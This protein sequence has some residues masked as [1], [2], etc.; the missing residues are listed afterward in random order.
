MDDLI[1]D[2]RYG[3]RTLSRSK[4]YAGA[5][6]LTLALGIGANAAIFSVFNALMFRPLPVRDAHELVVVASVDQH[7]PDGFPHGLSYLDSLDYAAFDEVLQ[8][9]AT[10]TPFIVSLSVDDVAER[11]FVELVS[12]NYF[13]MLGVKPHLGRLIGRDEGPSGGAGGGHAVIVLTESYWQRRFAA[14]PD[15]VGRAVRINGNPYTVIGVVGE[16]FP[17]TEFIMEMDAYVPLLQVAELSQSNGTMLENREGHSLRAMGRLQPGVDVDTARTALQVRAAQLAEAYPDTNKGVSLYVVP[18]TKARPEPG[19]SDFMPYIAMVFMGLVG[20]ILAIACANV[21]NMMLARATTRQREIA[22]RAALGASRFR[23]LRQ[24]LTESVALSAASA[25]V[26][27]ALAYWA[28]TALGSVSFSGDFPVRIDVSL[29]LRVF[30][31]ALALSLLTGVL[32]GLFPG[33]RASRANLH[34]NL[35]EGGRSSAVDPAQHWM[36]SALVVSQVAISLVVLI[37]AGLFLRSVRNVQNI[38]LGFRSDNLLLMSMD[39]TLGGYDEEFARPMFEEL[40][41]ST[42]QMPGVETAAHATFVPFGLISTTRP[43]FVPERELKE[44]EPES[45]GVMTDWVGLDFF[46]TIG[47]PIRQGRPFAREDSAGVAPVAVVNQAFVDEFWPGRTAL[48]R[49]I[50]LNGA[51]GPFVEV[52]GVAGNSYQRLVGEEFRP[53]LYLPW[54]QT[55]QG[56][57]VLH[58]Y[59]QGD[60]TALAAAIRDRARALAPGM[61]VY[62]VLTMADHLSG[63]NAFMAQRLAALVA[64]MFGAV[65]LILATIGI[66]GVVSYSVSQRTREIGVRMALGAAAGDVQRLIVLQASKVTL[67]GVVLGLLASV[68][69]T[70]LMGQLLLDVSPTDPVTFLAVTSALTTIAFA[71]SYIPA[72]RATRVDPIIAMRDE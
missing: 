22:V 3:I 31:F 21:A 47:I 36:R 14:D 54:S 25:A 17:G 70:R 26:A 15:V 16:S 20:L 30:G 72:R 51:A 5:A 63:G 65:G 49:Q 64:T 60:P 37:A 7:A 6:I 1:Q 28:T 35:K 24:L 61:P 9:L 39:A 27:L 59:A 42:R 33:L 34:D 18:E 56:A 40:I 12:A 45:V 19:T 55:Y 66:Y 68:A 38:D 32:A 8:D 2:L 23:I 58:I 50:S 67:A 41:E 29:D 4:G 44:G 43:V 48:G 53:F 57:R 69:I 46:N 52:V 71:A 10:Y 11:S 13:E 62:D